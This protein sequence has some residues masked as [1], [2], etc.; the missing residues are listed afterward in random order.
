MATTLRHLTRLRLAIRLP[1]E[2]IFLTEFLQVIPIDLPTS[3]RR[4]TSPN[5][6]TLS[7]RSYPHYSRSNGILL[8][9]SSSLGKSRRT[10][11]SNLFHFIPL[12]RFIL[13]QANIFRYQLRKEYRHPYFEVR[14]ANHAT[15]KIFSI[16]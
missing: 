15:K 13:S 8:F 4:P 16:F 11:F 6:Q 12:S 5:H 9:Y 7:L 3:I 2:V 1:G 10:N 14:W